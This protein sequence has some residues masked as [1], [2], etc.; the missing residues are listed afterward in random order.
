[1]DGAIGTD[2]L[3][4]VVIKDDALR[5]YVYQFLLSELGQNQ[6]KANVYGAIVDHVEPK[7]VKQI[8]VP[9][10][11]DGALVKAIGLR[12]LK[13][14]ELQEQAA[15]QMADSQTLLMESLEAD[16]RDGATA[17]KRL[18]EAKRDPSKLVRGK[19]LED[20]LARLES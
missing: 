7:D 13:G 18:A 14:I 15:E 17:R 12:V 19:A 8:I 2:D 1:L 4:R 5:G 11:D 9:V 10:P 16:K 20:E 3:I 6:L